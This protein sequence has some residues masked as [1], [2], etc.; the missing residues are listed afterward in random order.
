MMRWDCH[1]NHW[2]EQGDYDKIFYFVDYC[3]VEAN[4]YK[5][6]NQGQDE[7]LVEVCLILQQQLLF[8]VQGYSLWRPLEL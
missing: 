5:G 6:Q 4:S 8:L 1:P 7:L 2:H 3:V